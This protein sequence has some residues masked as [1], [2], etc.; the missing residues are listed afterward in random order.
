M[1]NVDAADN[2]SGMTGMTD[3]ELVRAFQQRDQEVI[4][5][6]D[7]R[8]GDYLLAICMNVLGSR[9]DSEECLNDAYMTGVKSA[10]VPK[11]LCRLMSLK[12]LSPKAVK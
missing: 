4:A 8:Y 10:A 11:R 6:V 2:I 5:R 1:R 3:P 7:A 9:E 12:E